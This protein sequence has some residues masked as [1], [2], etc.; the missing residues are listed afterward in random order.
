MTSVIV[1]SGR[2]SHGCRLFLTEIHIVNLLGMDLGLFDHSTQIGASQH[3]AARAL[4]HLV[5]RNLLRSVTETVR[6]EIAKSLVA[7]AL[8]IYLCGRIAM[9]GEHGTV[10]EADL[11]G[12]QGRLAF[13]R[14][15]LERGRPVSFDQL[16]DCVWG[17]QP[18]LDAA[19]ALASIISKLRVAPE[20]SRPGATKQRSSL[21]PEPTNCDCP[22]GAVSIF[23][24][25]GTPSISLKAIAAD[26]MWRLR[27]RMA[28][29]RCRL[30][31][32]AFFPARPRLGADCERR[33]RAG[34]DTWPRLPDMGVDRAKQ[35]GVGHGNGATSRRTRTPPRARVAC[36]HDHPSRVRQ[37]SGRTADVQPLPRGARRRTRRAARPCHRRALPAPP[38]EVGLSRNGMELEDVRLAV[39]L[40]RR[41]V[42][43]QVRAGTTTSQKSSERPVEPL[44]WVSERSTSSLGSPGVPL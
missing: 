34:G 30:H 41:T 16:I 23:R 29:S 2:S 19:G 33:T 8:R 24:T 11:P 3:G 42:P 18:P 10:D 5:H 32:E 26:T 38:L 31:V 40:R 12:R 39:S 28:L 17:D 20:T 13:A 35:R 4:D 25:L 6:R 9:I 43:R 37:S 21:A 7:M 14:L 1:R 15:C 27:G 22:A 44:I 36:A